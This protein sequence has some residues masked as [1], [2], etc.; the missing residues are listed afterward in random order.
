MMQKCFLPKSS[1][2]YQMKFHISNCERKIYKYYN[3]FALK[4]F[5]IYNVIINYFR[6]T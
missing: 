2:T 5:V 6:A 3:T 4:I 1:I